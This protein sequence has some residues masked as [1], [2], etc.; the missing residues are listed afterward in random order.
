MSLHG[1]SIPPPPHARPARGLHLP[2]RAH[3]PPPLLSPQPRPLSLAPSIGA[4]L[5]TLLAAPS[6]PLLLS[7]SKLQRVRGR[8]P[9]NWPLGERRA[10]LVLLGSWL[11][12]GVSEQGKINQGN[13]GECS[14]RCFLHIGPDGWNYTCQF[15]VALLP[16]WL[17]ALF[18][19]SLSLSVFSLLSLSLPS[20]MCH[21]PAKEIQWWKENPCHFCLFPLYLSSQQL[22]C[23]HMHEI[24]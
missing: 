18:F 7:P 8:W 11:I 4:R 20:F 14:E 10:I 5:W 22:C 13:R 23:L 19:L 16:N 21:R 3:S 2:P 15:L 24:S 6:P 12:I 17:S 1:F 9:E